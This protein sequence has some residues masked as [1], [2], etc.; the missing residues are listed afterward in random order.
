MRIL[1]I[2]GAAKWASI[3]LAAVETGLKNETLSEISGTIRRHSDRIVSANKEDLAAAEKDHLA[4][5][6]M[7]RLKFDEGKIAQ[8][9]AGIESL[10]RL[11]D[12]VGKTIAA[13]ELDAGLELYKVSCPIGVIGVVFE[14]R[15]DALV[16][17]STLCLKSGNAPSC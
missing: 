12:P 4:T 3:R 15:P 9:I 13:T 8:V 6:L 2:A 16:Q 10:I 17:I 14:S 1:D 11:E 5:P 7:K